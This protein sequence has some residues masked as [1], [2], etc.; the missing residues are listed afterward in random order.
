MLSVLRAL[1]GEFTSEAVPA[2]LGSLRDRA[3]KATVGR[4]PYKELKVK[5]GRDA[6]AL[7]PA[8]ERYI[9]EA[10]T[11]Y[12]RFRRVCALSIVANSMEFDVRGFK[13]SFRDFQK[14]LKKPKLAVDHLGQTYRL[15]R[16][17]KWV[18]FLTDNA[19]EIVFDSLLLR[20]LKEMGLK[21]TVAVK[22]RPVL[23][24]ATLK[25]AREA[26]VDGIVDELITT[27][28]DSVG[29]LWEET[30]AKVKRIFKE[31]D[32]VIVKGMGNYETLSELE[33]IGVRVL[34]LLKAKCSPIARSIGVKRGANV[35]LLTGC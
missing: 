29:L 19:G 13:F 25:E 21:V 16:E 1:E 10:R 11:S 20:Y 7:L 32:L 23:N 18:L 24:D 22:D 34:F 35:A 14:S 31:A 5:A 27:G 8:A 26:G 15:L 3:V 33:G 9:S 17:S 4:D 28:S 30:S 6:L 2:V 12:Q